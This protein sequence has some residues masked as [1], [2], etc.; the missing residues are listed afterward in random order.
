MSKNTNCVHFMLQDFFFLMFFLVTNT[1][2]AI[3]YFSDFIYLYFVVIKTFNSEKLIYYIRVF[4]YIYTYTHTYSC[5]LVAQSC[6][7]LCDP[8]DG[9]MS[10]F[11]V[12]YHLPE[13]VQTHGH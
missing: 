6:P 12:L 1:S 4:N 8:M 3:P 2:C 13:L 7:T 5:C 9:S 10:G 11:P